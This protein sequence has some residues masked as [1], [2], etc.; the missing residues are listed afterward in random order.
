MSGSEASGV[1]RQIRMDRIDL[2][3]RKNVSAELRDDPSSLM[4]YV[5][6]DFRTYVLGMPSDRLVLHRKWPA[7]WVQAVKERWLPR[8]ILKRWPVRYDRIDLDVQKYARIC[9][10]LEGNHHD[11]VMFMTGHEEFQA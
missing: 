5:Q 2:H 10:H 4:D 6:W 7:D 11:C 9:P 8:W 1:V 3:L